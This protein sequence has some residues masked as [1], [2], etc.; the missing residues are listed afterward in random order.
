MEAAAGGVAIVGTDIPGIR[1]LVENGESG[2]LVPLRD[3]AAL[4]AAIGRVLSDD[5]LRAGLA[6]RARARLLERHTGARLARDFEAA[7]AALC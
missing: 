1:D 6:R 7:Y 2:L 4:A 5:A 3:P